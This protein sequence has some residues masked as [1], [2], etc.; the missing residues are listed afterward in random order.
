MSSRLISHRL[1]IVVGIATLLTAS[2]L[3]AQ[4]RPDRLVLLGTGGGPAVKASRAQPA[5]AV[6]VNGAVYVVDAGDGVARQMALAGLPVVALRAVFITHHHSDHNADYG[7]LLLR[8]WASGLRR[9]VATYGP[10]PLEGITRSYLEYMDWDIRLRVEDENRPVL[11]ELIQAHDIGGDGPVYRDENIVVT[12]A[13]VPHG[14]AAPAYAYRVDTA[15]GSVVFSGDTTM[16][17]ALVELAT[18]ADV[19][20]HEVVSIEGAAA[21]VE[22]LDPGNE[23]LLR[24]IIE[25]H[26]TAEDVGR[27]AARAGVERL[28]LTHLRAV[29]SSR[30]RSAR[31]LAR[32]R[33]PPLRGRGHRRARPPGDR[34]LTP[35]TGAAPGLRTVTR[36]TLPRA[37]RREPAKNGLH[38]RAVGHFISI[39][40]LS[41]DA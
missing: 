7:T 32:G 22:R 29:R 37:K 20:V 28:V 34:L 17:D 27:V 38:L 1:A 26:T 35:S 13:E 3:P 19:L 16:S 39:T 8:A 18:G 4:E 15:R 9:P 6:V 5:N 40:V 10:P 33:A 23:A 30:V 14:A 25:A 24:H 21:I 31:A 41:R 11:G 2:P 36:I 12:A